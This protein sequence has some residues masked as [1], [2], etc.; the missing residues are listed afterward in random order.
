MLFT[1]LNVKAFLVP[2]EFAAIVPP[3]PAVQCNA[4]YIS[5]VAAKPAFAVAAAASPAP[6]SP[7][8]PPTAIAAKTGAN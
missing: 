6:P 8:V 5:L 1:A 3:S 7:T 4:R 2:Q